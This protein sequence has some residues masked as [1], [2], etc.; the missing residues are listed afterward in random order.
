MSTKSK[1]RFSPS[2]FG[3]FLGGYFYFKN[4]FNCT[5]IFFAWPSKF[6]F[7]NDIV[8]KLLWASYRILWA[9]IIGL[10]GV[11]RAFDILLSSLKSVIF[12]FLLLL[13]SQNKS[14]LSI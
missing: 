5:V 2:T 4:L 6:Q 11:C 8:S 7:F 10:V 3:Y 1:F 12:E 14:Y 13:T 9:F